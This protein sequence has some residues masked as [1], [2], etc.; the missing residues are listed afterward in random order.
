MINAVAE[1]FLIRGENKDEMYRSL[2]PQLSALC[3]GESD[4]IANLG[5][6]LAGL[7][8]SFGFL[9]VG[10]YF[11]RGGDLVLGPFQG[12]VAC[13]RIAFGKGVC[14][15]CWKDRKTLVVPDVDQ[16]P[17]HIAC[18]SAS[19]SEIVLPG[20][21]SRGEV[22]FVLDVDSERLDNF[23]EVD[24]KYLGEVVGMIQKLVTSE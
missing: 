4:T 19:R 17:G 8:Q 7:R 6:I 10:I 14:G 12:P 20:T 13:S 22:A 18:S 16:F 2:L 9:W 21:D 24:E 1:T 15:T 11:V 5:N 23:D 3:E